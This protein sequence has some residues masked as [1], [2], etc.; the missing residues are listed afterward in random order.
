MLLRSELQHGPNIRI[1]PK[2]GNESRLSAKEH[3]THVQQRSYYTKLMVSANMVC[4][5]MENIKQTFWATT[6]SLE[7]AEDFGV[8]GVVDMTS[9][10]KC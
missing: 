8:D 3:S 1:S 10:M 9:S 2:D 4:A 6:F 5:L 7:V